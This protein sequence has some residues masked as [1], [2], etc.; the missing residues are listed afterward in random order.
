MINLSKEGVEIFQTSKLISSHKEAIQF[1]HNKF[2]GETCYV[3]GC[4]PSI[5]EAL[6]GEGR[7]KLIEELGNNYVLTIKAA[8]KL[9]EKIK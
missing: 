1:L 3:L 7:V 6:A 8:H 2:L 9:C 4:G 5:G